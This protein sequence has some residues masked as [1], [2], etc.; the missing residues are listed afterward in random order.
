MNDCEVAFVPRSPIDLLRALAQHAAYR[1]MLADCG[2][3]VSTLPP[4]D[5]SPDCVFVEDTAV[6]LDEIA[7]LASPGAPSRRG[8]IVAV[9]E[10]LRPFRP[11]ERIQLPA[12]LDG[13]DVLL[14]GRTLLVGRSARTNTAGIESLREIAGPRGYRVLPVGIQHCLHLKSACTALDDQTLIVNR[15]WLGAGAADELGRAY[16]LVD[17]P[18][19]EPFAADVLRIGSTICLP[20]AHPRTAEQ[21]AAR[22]HDV[23]T[24][25]LSEFAKAE[26]GVTCLSL[27]FASP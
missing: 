23:R 21:I 12:T 11:T 19:T 18:Q 8:E 20:A 25:D 22:G 9:E 2:A 10:A 16:R 6:V 17:I 7:I 26:G 5:E 24:I 3:D 27:V 13:G 14:A 4:S 15:Q 1:A